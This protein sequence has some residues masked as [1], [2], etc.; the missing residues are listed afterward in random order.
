M[1]L[2]RVVL[3]KK[4]T[5]VMATYNPNSK[6]FKEQLESIEN[7][8]YKNLELL[9]LDD[10]SA[11]EKF[12]E[13]KRIAAEI[14]EN[15]PF[16][17]GKNDVNLGSNKTFEILVKKATGFYIGLADQDDIFDAN[18]FEKLVE[19][20]QGE[21]AVLAYSDARVIDEDGNQTHESFKGYAKRVVHM[22]GENI[23]PSFIRRNSVTGCTM[24]I[25]MDVAKMSLP[26]PD[27]KSYVHDHW[28][29]LIAA[30]Q[31]KIAY[32]EKPLISYRIHGN[33]Q[34]GSSLLKGVEDKSTYIECKLL[35]EKQKYIALEEKK[36]LLS[37]EMQIEVQKYLDN[38][39]AR[40]DFYGQANLRNFIRVTSTRKIDFQLF[41]YEILLAASPKFI[42]RKLISTYK[43]T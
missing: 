20:I 42:Q 43:G 6:F 35:V 14:L 22:H 16:Q 1:T 12:E 39:K 3:D 27:Y 11:L 41:V 28:M 32:S 24:L 38:M 33:N 23:G 19:I 26:F 29:T 15:V 5:I 13:I 18:K 10:C 36:N 2:R 8:S 30:T 21:N 4:I 9:I 40:I 37:E 25:R 7:Q 34:I 17:I 31:G